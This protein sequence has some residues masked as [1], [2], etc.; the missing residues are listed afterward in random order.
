MWQ[1]KK[2]LKIYIVET[3]QMSKNEKNDYSE[4][5]KEEYVPVIYYVSN[6]EVKKNILG[7]ITEEE[8]ENFIE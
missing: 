4:K 7:S 1:K 3:S 5:F 6:G 8:M 2:K